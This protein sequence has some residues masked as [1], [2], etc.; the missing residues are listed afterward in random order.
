MY[1]FV[2]VEE[3]KEDHDQ[4]PVAKK[5][6]MLGDRDPN[7][8]KLELEG[9][10]SEKKPQKKNSSH[11]EKNTETVVKTDVKTVDKEVLDGIK[12]EKEEMETSDTKI[13]AEKKVESTV[14]KVST[15][16]SVKEG[17]TAT[18]DNLTVAY[19]PNVAIGK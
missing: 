5:Y 3:E 17:N 10:T 1:Y 6:E 8:L 13:T 14:E 16:K 19:D 4:M 9:G 15:I 7:K 2:N 12:K 18:K 11:A